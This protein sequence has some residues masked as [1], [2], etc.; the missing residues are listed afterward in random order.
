MPQLTA[1]KILLAQDTTDSQRQAADLLDQLHDF[2]TSIHNNCFR[3]DVLALQALLHDARGEDSA[4]VEKLSQSLDLEEPG[5]FIRLFVDLG[6]QMAELLKQLIKQNVAVD[7]IGQILAAFREDEHRT[8]PGE[9]DL[10]TA[11]P[12]PLSTQP[13]VEALTN[14]ELQILD[15]LAQRLRNKEIAEKLFI[16]PETVKKHLNNI[17]GK[18]SVSGRRQAVERA[19]HLGILTRL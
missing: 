1:I 4:A 9:S 10:P 19:M 18:L 2:L 3:I 11:H 14:R 16:S 8:M 6:P 17:Y 5:G 7:Y 13:L 15:L 12:P